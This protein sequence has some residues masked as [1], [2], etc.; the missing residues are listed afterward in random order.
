MEPSRVLDLKTFVPARDYDLA[1]QFYS[2]LGFKLNWD[3]DQ[4]AEFQL[5]GFRFFLQNLYVEEYA[6]NFMMQLMVDDADTWWKHIE[7][8]GLKTNYPKHHG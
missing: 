3:N 1:R 2:D 4:I 6:S 8:V 7:E 5:G